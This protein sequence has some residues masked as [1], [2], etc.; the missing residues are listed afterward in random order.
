MP[1]LHGHEVWARARAELEGLPHGALN[2]AHEAVDRH[3]AGAARDRVAVRFLPRRGPPQELTYAQLRRRTDRFA[4]VLRDLGVERGECVATLLG[5]S[6]EVHVAAHGTLKQGAVFAALSAG[7]DAGAVADQL[8]LAEVR[9]L[10]TTPAL[11]A[12]AVAP[13][14]GRLVALRHVLLVGSPDEVAA[15]PG[16]LDLR[17][18]LAGAR[19]G[20]H[21]ARTDPT[22]LALVHLEGAPSGPPLGTLHAHEA[23]VAHHATAGSALDLRAGDVLWCSADLASV[24]GLAYGVIGALT[25][26]ATCLVADA[27]EPG[28]ATRVLVEERVDVWLTGPRPL[29]GPGPAP[30]LPAL[31]R[32]VVPGAPAP[33]GL[34][35]GLARSLGRPVLE[36]F[37][38]PETGAIVLCGDPARPGA[39]RPLPG[40]EAEVVA[41]SAPVEPVAPGGAGELA[42]RAGWPSMVCGDLRD[43]GRLHRRFADGWYLTG[44]AAR[45]DEDG[46]LVLLGPARART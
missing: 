46:R 35:E 4:C 27:L 30:P 25:R 36:A 29:P 31:R 42:L 26:G 43:E 20:H 39:V 23:V 37:C 3:A 19:G 18:A 8:D 6:P 1:A 16:A 15:V 32:V 41:P 11:H 10:V 40:V 5:P 12:R 13:A 34:L 33:A 28:E 24:P 17:A 2:I 45:R 21:A 9:V 22:E 44:Q 14:R 38:Q 7:L